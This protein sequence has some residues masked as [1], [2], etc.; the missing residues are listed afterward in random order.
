MLSFKIKSNIFEAKKAVSISSKD[1]A[2]ERESISDIE[3][4]IIKEIKEIISDNFNLPI[5]FKYNSDIKN[6]EMKTIALIHTYIYI[7][8][9]ISL[10]WKK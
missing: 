8:R 4:G 5:G 1:S 10:V 3:K 9:P 7:L 6:D 2:P